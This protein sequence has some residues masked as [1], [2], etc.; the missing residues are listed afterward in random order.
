MKKRPKLGRV[1]YR[2][3]LPK[4]EKVTP[5]IRN[6]FSF[7]QAAAFQW[8]NP[9][10]WAIAV[11]ALATFSNK[12]NFNSGILSVIVAYFFTGLI[13]MAFWLKLGQSLRSLL[14]TVP[15]VRFFNTSMAVLLVL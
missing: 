8:L 2:R 3:W 13:C 9:K 4:G 12:E 14:N 6:P 1:S 10:A 7:L 11:G 15:R 5:G